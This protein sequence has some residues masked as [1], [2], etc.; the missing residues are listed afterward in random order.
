MVS[1]RGARGRVERK[2][3]IVDLGQMRVASG[4]AENDGQAGKRVKTVD[5]L[6]TAGGPAAPAPLGTQKIEQY[7]AAMEGI[8]PKA[9]SSATKEEA[10]VRGMA[11]LS[12]QNRGLKR[13]FCERAVE[14]VRIVKRLRSDVSESTQVF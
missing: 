6:E 3:D 9:D 14:P 13:T 4:R 1:R 12:V 2:L 7:D 5:F 8:E 11:E 10:H